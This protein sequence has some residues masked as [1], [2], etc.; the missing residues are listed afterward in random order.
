M[1]SRFIPKS[2][3]RNLFHFGIRGKSVSHEEKS[4][5]TESIFF[6]NIIQSK[7]K[8]RCSSQSTQK[9]PKILVFQSKI[10]SNAVLSIPES[11]R[12]NLNP[13]NRP[14]VL[15][16]ETP[17]YQNFYQKLQEN[18]YFHMMDFI[19]DSHLA[20]GLGNQLTII[21]DLKKCQSAN[22]EIKIKEL[23]TAVKCEVPNKR[24]LVG[25]LEGRL[26]EVDSKISRIY[27]LF[28]KQETASR[29]GVVEC[30]DNVSIT[31]NR[32]GFLIGY[33][34]R[35]S[36]SEIFKIK[37]HRMEICGL[38][39]NPFDEHQLASGG[40]DNLCKLYDLRK[41]KC[42]HTF[43][44][45][46]AAVRAIAW[47]PYTQGMLVTGGGSGDQNLCVW[48]TRTFEKQQKKNLFSQICNVDFSRDDFIITTHGWPK[49]NVQFRNKDLGEL[50]SF[51]ESHNRILYL[52]VNPCRDKISTGSGDKCVTIWDVK[53]LLEKNRN[54]G[55]DFNNQGTSRIR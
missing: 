17:I 53:N 42:F 10:L 49:N 51:K 45:H 39:V 5:S 26:F 29:I 23:I 37:A 28:R 40:N 6:E 13:I 41:L 34:R 12:K 27:T 21:N 2:V 36:T 4:S 44:E 31:G 46:C 54:S 9:T 8:T 43:Q 14:L 24:I 38:K 25:T 35:D 16:R 52:A 1:S 22:K 15:F 47:S 55:I 33:D 50:A 11:P 30:F 20:I 7:S 3:N 18:F 32:D 48:N 19:D